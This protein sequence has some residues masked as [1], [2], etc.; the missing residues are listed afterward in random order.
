MHPVSTR[1]LIIFDADRGTRV[2]AIKGN[3][4]V[5]D[6]GRACITD[7]GVYTSVIQ[8]TRGHRLRIPLQWPYKSPEELLAG[9]Q[10]SNSDVYSF[11]CTVYS[12][13]CIY[14]QG[15]APILMFYNTDVY[16]TQSLCVSSRCAADHRKRSWRVTCRFT[17][18]RTQWCSLDCFEPLLGNPACAPSNN[19][20]SWGWAKG[21]KAQLMSSCGRGSD[22]TWGSTTH[23]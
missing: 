6:D 12:V 15:L 17:T 8:T 7:V 3:V 9:V 21:A 11:A 20:G 5:M 16:R 22:G 14:L 23:I 2:L 19:E 4:L 1:S 10:T 13:S 18:R